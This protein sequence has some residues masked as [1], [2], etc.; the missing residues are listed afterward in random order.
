MLTLL[1]R[2]DTAAEKRGFQSKQES[3]KYYT[4]KECCS[5]NHGGGPEKA[6]FASGLGAS[7]PRFAA[8]LWWRTP[9]ARSVSFAALAV[10]VNSNPH[11][12]HKSVVLRQV[13]SF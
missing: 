8:L 1:P 2:P 5:Y 12:G 7:V 3:D 13:G 10:A 11:C 9:P 4:A 6:M